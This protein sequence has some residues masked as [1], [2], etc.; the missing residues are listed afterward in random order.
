MTSASVKI[1]GLQIGRN[2]YDLNVLKLDFTRCNQISEDGLQSLFSHL[3]GLSQLEKLKLN[4]TGYHF[5]LILRLNL[6]Y[7]CGHATDKNLKLLGS[8]ISRNLA[9][10]QELALFF[11]E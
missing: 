3:K 4:F 2:L 1:L 7:S 11:N 5:I 10:L 6:I 8:V 9:K